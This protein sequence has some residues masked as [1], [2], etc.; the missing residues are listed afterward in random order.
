MA[1]K[2]EKILGLSGYA[3]QEEES[4]MTTTGAK[5]S[6]RGMRSKK[7]APGVHIFKFAGLARFLVRIAR[8]A[9]VAAPASAAAASVAGSAKR[10]RLLFQ[11]Q[12]LIV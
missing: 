11:R 1:R 10:A 2:R 3:F 8:A 7:S 5:D 4:G 12:M 9:A 6:M